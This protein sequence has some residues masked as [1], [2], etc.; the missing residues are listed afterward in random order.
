[1]KWKQYKMEQFEKY[2]CFVVTFVG[3][4]LVGPLKECNRKKYIATAVCYFMKFVEAKLI[5]DKTGEQVA[6]FIYELMSRY[7]VFETAISD[8]GVWY[9]INNIN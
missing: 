2:F 8:Q 3:I 4:D 9:L 1:M 7:G 5:P 6:L